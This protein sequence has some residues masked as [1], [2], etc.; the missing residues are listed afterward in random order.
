MKKIITTLIIV[1]ILIGGYAI[2]T[3]NREIVLDTDIGVE[4]NNKLL[5]HFKEVFESEVPVK[6]GYA[7]I[8]NDSI[9]D[10]VVVYRDNEQDKNFMCAVLDFKDEYFITESIPAPYENVEIQF[11]DID[12]KDEMEFIVSGSK[13]GNYGY[14]IYRLSEEKQLRDLFSENMEDCC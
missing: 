6:A 9:P 1:A 12:E 11:K 2:Y 7:D 3:I 10:L 5:R 14:A 4:E 13:D 8:N